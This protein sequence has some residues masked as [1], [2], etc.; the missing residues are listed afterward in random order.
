[1]GNII[2]LIDTSYEI[3][4][5]TDLNAPI[6]AYFELLDQPA[7]KIPYTPNEETTNRYNKLLFKSKIR[8]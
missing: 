4:C 1:M 7:N 2:K 8:V 5:E 3:I 6:N